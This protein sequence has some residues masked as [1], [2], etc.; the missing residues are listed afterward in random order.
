MLSVAC[1]TAAACRP[2]GDGG[3]PSGDGGSIQPGLTYHGAIRPLLEAHCVGCHTDDAVAPFPLDNWEDVRVRSFRVVDAVR[4]GKMPPAQFD[5]DCREVLG[6]RWMPEEHRQRFLRW[7]D[8]GY[9]EGDPEEYRPP[10]TDSQP[11]PTPVG[12]PDLVVPM[13][14]PYTPS[15][16]EQGDDFYSVVLE[17]V[18]PETTYISA[19]RI[20]P[21]EPRVVHHASVELSDAEGNN[22][23]GEDASSHEITAT[24]AG[25]FPG[26]TD[27]VLPEGAAF[28]VPAGAHLRLGIHY[29]LG[30]WSED[31]WPADQTE[32]HFWT[33]P[34]DTLP[35]QRAHMLALF[36]RDLDIAAGDP[37]SVQSEERHWSGNPMKVIGIGP[38]MHFWGTEARLEAIRP[39]GR[40]DCLAD[41][42]NYD[43]DWQVLYHYTDRSG[44][45]LDTDDRMRLTCVYDNS[46]DNQPTVSGT[47]LRTEDR[48]FGSS[49]LDEMCNFNLLALEAIE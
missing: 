10:T 27:I 26:F 39:D 36:N 38:H 48:S 29:H 6:Q 1:L 45:S 14:E 2:G 7:A 35:L 33:L 34:P 47:Q 46:E 17:Y 20:V 28:V 11:A 8:R 5:P 13:P 23:T 18:F 9:P 4:S 41:V 30:W 12:E 25:Y 19:S 21:S 24:V 31:D 42:P 43:F 37:E 32:V 15:P 3:A 49:S 22:L 16:S 44:V 40:V